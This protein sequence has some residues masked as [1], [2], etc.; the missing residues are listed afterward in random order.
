MRLMKHILAVVLRSQIVMIK[1]FSSRFLGLP[2]MVFLAG[3]ACAADSAA[4][5]ELKLAVNDISYLWPVP[6]NQAEVDQLISGESVWPLKNFA[7][8]TDMAQDVTVKDGGGTTRHIIFPT[9]ADFANRATWKLVGFRVDPS[10]PSTDHSSISVVGSIP[11]IRLIMQPVT[12]GPNGV[13]VHDFAAHLAFSYV[14]NMTPPFKPD[15]VT[16]A[17]ILDDLRK[18]KGFLLAADPPVSTEGMLD[19]NRGLAQNVTGFSGQIENFL[20][21]YL[22]K[23]SPTQ[24]A[25]MG[26]SSPRPEPWIFFVWEPRKADPQLKVML[27]PAITVLKG[28]VTPIPENHN[29]APISTAGVST[30]VLFRTNPKL[31]QPAVTGL[32]TPLVK[33]IPNIIA[34]PAMVNV[35]NTDCVSCHSETTRRTI[36]NIQ[37]ANYKFELPP[38]IPGV[39]PTLLPTNVYNVRNFGWF[40]NGVAAPQPAITMRTSNET[41][42]A[43]EFIRKN[44]KR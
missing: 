12:V 14:L 32:A 3:Y 42:N 10:A 30:A 11:Q 7:A 35:L 25:F 16:F 9:S 5:T 20:H 4:Q 22:T 6:S 2:L 21:K 31:D 29:L 19:V 44:Y 13:T 24:V 36:L 38:G 39:K 18:L 43:L 1:Y 27:F 17:A 37:T 41:A 33:D 28:A 23:L 8:V 34:N 26:V 40:Q 15:R